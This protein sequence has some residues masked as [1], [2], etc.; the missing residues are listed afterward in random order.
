MISTQQLVKC[1]LE[2]ETSFKSAPLSRVTY[3]L[4]DE[5]DDY[6]FIAAPKLARIVELMTEA[7]KAECFCMNDDVP[8]GIV[9][10]QACDALE[11]CDEIAGGE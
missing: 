2:L 5:M 11:A 4:I 1:V 9:K 6:Y 8:D 3:K 7:L 10:C